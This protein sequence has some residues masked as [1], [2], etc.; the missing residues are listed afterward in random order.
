[1]ARHPRRLVHD[2][3]LDDYYGISRYWVIQDLG[4]GKV[5]KPHYRPQFEPS[6]ADGRYLCAVCSTRFSDYWEYE[7]HWCIPKGEWG[8]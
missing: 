6:S 4:V 8:Q 5:R 3:V 1:V 7:K 2:T